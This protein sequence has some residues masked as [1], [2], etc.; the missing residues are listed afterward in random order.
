MSKKITRREFLR[1]SL[2]AA[3][4]MAALCTFGKNIFPFEKAAAAEGAVDLTSLSISRDM[5]KCIGCGRCAEICTGTQGLDILTLGEKDG[6]TVSTLKYGSCL[7]ETKCIGCGQCARVCPSGA[8]SVKDGLTAVNDALN[9]NSKYIVWQFAPSV[10]HIIGEEFRILSGVDVSGKLAAA[11]ELLGGRA[12]RTDFGADITIMEE[13]AEFVECLN[14]GVKKPFMTSCCPGWVNY[15]ELNYPELIPHLSSCKSPMEMLG[16]LIKDYLPQKYNVSASDIFHIAVMPCTAKKYEA[17]RAEMNIS[18]IQ[19]VDAVITVTEF[20][21]LLLSRNIDLTVLPDKA[22]DTLFDGTSGSGRI[23]GASGGVCEAALRTVYYNITGHELDNAEFSELRGSGAVKTAELTAGG[24]TIR[25]CVVNGIGNIKTIAESILNGTCEYDF[26]EVMACPGGCAG[27]GGTPLL[28]GDAGVRH[29][30][31]YSYDAHNSVHSSH[32]NE[33]LAD[34]YSEY[35]SNPC[36]EKSEELL[37]TT[38]RERR[39]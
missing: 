20:K 17:R 27:G 4:G 3:A 22:F 31:M 28:F 37:H 25:A 35:L 10:Q 12:Y 30:G 36:S 8:I 18:G 26:I 16:A 24:K 32:N 6:R 7:S 38:Y 14:S 29:R 5:S 9:D 1:D 34:I 11:A 39:Q 15:V 33:T 13:A 23:F 2:Y 21:N 19:A